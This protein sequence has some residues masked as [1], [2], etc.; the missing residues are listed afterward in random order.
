[1]PSFIL[2][3]SGVRTS[4]FGTVLGPGPAL[5][6]LC[7]S[8]SSRKGRSMGGEEPLDASCV[9]SYREF[10]EETDWEQLTTLACELQAHEL[11]LHDRMKLAIDGDCY[12]ERLKEACKA[13]HG[14]ILVCVEGDD[15]TTMIVGYAVV[16][17]KVASNS[18][19]EVSYEYG[20]VLDLAVTA[21]A[22][23]QG[24]GTSLLKLCEEKVRAKGCKYLR[25]EVLQEPWLHIKSLASRIISLQWKKIELIPHLREF[26]HPHIHSDHRTLRIRPTRRQ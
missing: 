25:T 9:H 12:I 20:E 13:H 7:C 23:Q 17:A 2:S 6:G 4:R 1:M 3:S 21:T 5:P 18:Y 24:I 14:S 8:F 26:D 15:A 22:R 19:D 16:L 10:N 11:S